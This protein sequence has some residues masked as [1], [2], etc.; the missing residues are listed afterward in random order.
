[1]NE[2]KRVLSVAYIFNVLRKNGLRSDY[3]SLVLRNWNDTIPVNLDSDRALQH[4][5]RDDQLIVF[6]DL[7]DD[8]LYA[9]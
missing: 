2:S 7:Y 1:M 3:L 5:Y 9:A 6:L 4:A 8:S